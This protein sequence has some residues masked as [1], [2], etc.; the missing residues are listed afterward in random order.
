[1][2]RVFD[3]DQI[4]QSQRRHKQKMRSHKRSCNGKVRYHTKV[5]AGQALSHMTAI[6]GSDNL[7]IYRC[8]N[9][10]L[11]HIGHHQPKVLN[12]L[13]QLSTK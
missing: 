4:R 11:Y 10:K 2:A 5:D 3:Y 9:C 13:D 8:Q 6:N 12:I 7:R 1:M